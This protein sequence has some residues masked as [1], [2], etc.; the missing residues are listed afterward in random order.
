[1]TLVVSI[2]LVLY[3]YV[4]F[5]DSCSNY[6]RSNGTTC[7]NGSLTV[8]SGYKNCTEWQPAA[9]TSSCG[10]V[11][12]WATLTT[13]NSSSLPYARNVTSCDQI[14]NMKVVSTCNNGKFDVVP[15]NS[16]TCSIAAPVW[17][18]NGLSHGQTVTKHISNNCTVNANNSNPLDGS[19][20]ESCSC[21][22]GSQTC[23]NGVLSNTAQRPQVQNGTPWSC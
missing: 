14:S 2:L 9:C 17:C 15:G 19:E 6:L 13:Y 22:Y 16:C 8:A 7:T 10:T 5:G 4:E 21:I 1:V 12:N 23:T 3:V 11:A 18:N 20:A